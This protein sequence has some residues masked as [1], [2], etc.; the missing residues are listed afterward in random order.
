LFIFLKYEF[1]LFCLQDG[2]R[3]VGVE[4]T[5]LYALQ[6]DTYSLK[7]K[8]GVFVF[9]EN[10][11]NCVY[12]VID[13]IRDMERT[14]RVR[15]QWFNIEGNDRRVYEFPMMFNQWLNINNFVFVFF[16]TIIPKIT[17]E[18][19][20]NLRYHPMYNLKFGTLVIEFEEVPAPDEIFT[21]GKVMGAEKDGKVICLHY[22]LLSYLSLNCFN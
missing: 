14:S 19:I 20:Q 12:G 17:N 6:D 5:E 18:S 8:P 15:V 16:R 3:D 4:S 21:V 11:K 9:P 1:I 10:T 7:Y 13:S 22:L 2:T